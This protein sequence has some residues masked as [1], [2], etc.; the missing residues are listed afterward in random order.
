MR[1]LTEGELREKFPKMLC[2]NIPN[3]I[4]DSF[5]ESRKG[6]RQ[7]PNFK[8]FE[9][10]NKT[11]QETNYK[12]DGLIY[13]CQIKCLYPDYPG[14][15]VKCLC[16]KLSNDGF[17]YTPDDEIKYVPVNGKQYFEGDPPVGRHPS[18]IITDGQHFKWCKLDPVYYTHFKSLIKFSHDYLQSNDKPGIN[19]RI[20][21]NYPFSRIDYEMIS[22]D[23]HLVQITYEVG[24]PCNN[25]NDYWDKVNPKLIGND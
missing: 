17:L 2:L 24:L 25:F 8:N 4:F 9:L 11:P 22:A 20:W 3:A 19:H 15:F 6:Q 10:N 7:I 5:L 18:K 1:I 16:I 12:H 21:Y 23:R 14:E 13:K